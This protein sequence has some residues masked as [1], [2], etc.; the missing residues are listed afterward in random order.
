MECNP[1]K[2]SLALDPIHAQCQPGISLLPCFIRDYVRDA[3]LPELHVRWN[4][5]IMKL[6]C[7]PAEQRHSLPTSAQPALDLA[8]AGILGSPTSE[9]L[10]GLH[11][12]GVDGLV[13]D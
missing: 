4:M 13:G 12:L 1:R 11:Q 7:F 8:Q 9:L 10:V 3:Q 2:C 6:C 5:C